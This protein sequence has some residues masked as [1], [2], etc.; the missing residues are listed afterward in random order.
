MR[1]SNFGAAILGHALTNAAD[2]TLYPTLLE[3][4]ILAPLNLHDTSCTATCPPH[5]T[6]VTGYRRHHAQHPLRMPGLT[7]AGSLRSSVRDLLA[8]VETLL[9]PPSGAIP[10]TL[11]TALDVV[12]RPRLRMPTGNSLALVWNIRPRPDGSIVYHHS[13]GTFGCTAFAAFT[14]PTTAPPW[15]PWRTPRGRWWC[16]RCQLERSPVPSR[17]L[18]ARCRVA[19]G[20]MPLCLFRAGGWRSR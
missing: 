6:Q 12:L 18:R 14:P 19:R 4:R 5:T 1:Y 17:R 16:G 2:S 20:E 13:G 8:L 3:T 7:P 15:S 11:R 10:P 9:S